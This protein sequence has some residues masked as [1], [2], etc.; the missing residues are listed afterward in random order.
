DTD[1]AALLMLAREVHAHEYKVAFTGEGA[2]EWLGG[3]PWYKVH[4]LAALLDFI[5]GLKLS[6]LCRRVYLKLS[7]AP[8]FPWSL[9][10]RNQDAVAGH[11]AW[12]DIYGLMSMSKLRLFSRRMLELCLEDI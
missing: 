9:A 2:A 10:C 3:Y 1:C 7:G 5:P 6:Q 11:N 4:R 8:R 12:L